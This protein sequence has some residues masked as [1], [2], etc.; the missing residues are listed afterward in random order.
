MIMNTTNKHANVLKIDSVITRDGKE[1]NHNNETEGDM[2]KRNLMT[3]LTQ[4][5]L[6]TTK[7]CVNHF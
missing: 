7:F 5:T 4:M 2:N 6:M 1:D 3:M